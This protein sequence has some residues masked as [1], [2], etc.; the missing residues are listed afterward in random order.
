MVWNRL[1]LR[2]SK[3][4]KKSLSKLLKRLEILIIQK[5]VLILLGD[6]QINKI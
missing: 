3:K 2:T 4:N 6:A 1:D 5:F